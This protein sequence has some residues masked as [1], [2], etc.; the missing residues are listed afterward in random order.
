MSR[1]AEIYKSEK[2]KGGGL[3]SAVGKRF[4]EKVDPRK[5]FDQKGLMAAMLPSLF[6]SYSAT[7]KGRPR[8]TSISMPSISMPSFSSAAVEASLDDIYTSNKMIAKNSMVLPNIH[9][10]VNVMRQ[11]VVKLVKL[12]GGTAAT[13]ADMFFSKAKDREAMYES[14]FQKERSARTAEASK[15]TEGTSQG[16]F[17][18]ALLGGIGKAASGIGSGVAIASLGAGIGGFFTGLAAGGSAVNKLGGASGVKDMLIS[19]AQGLNAFNTQSLV[20]LGGMLGTGM[21]F[22]AVTGPAGAL[23]LGGGAA[24]G[25]TMIGAG[26]GGFMLALSAGAKVAQELGGPKA[27]KELLTSLGEGLD[28][29]TRMDGSNMLNVGKGIAALSAGLIGLFAAEGIKEIQNGYKWLKGLIF[30]EDTN[31]KSFFEELADQLRKLEVVDS[32][33]IKD[34]GE[35]FKDLVDSVDKLRSISDE[36][37]ALVGKKI[38]TISEQAKA[39][40]VISSQIKSPQFGQGNFVKAAQNNL[41]NDGGFIKASYTAAESTSPTSYEP[42]SAS[43]K[44]EM[45]NLIRQKFKAAGFTDIQ[46]EA[47]VANAIRESGLNPNAHNRVG[48]DSVGLFQMNRDRGLG[49]GYTV[50]QLKDPNFNIDLAIEAAKKSKSF[51]DA[52]TINGA[53]TAFVQDVERP[54]NQ[55]DEID[56]RIAIANAG[57]EVGKQ[58]SSSSSEVE[59]GKRQV[60]APVIIAPQTQTAQNAQQPAVSGQLAPADVQD[61]S[62]MKELF[63]KRAI[64]Y[65]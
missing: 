54:A 40:S 11:N 58:I 48:E 64:Q 53:I 50:E 47:A 1:I 23:A 16:G 29:F 5:I 3:A 19:L 65:I 18:G 20:A 39:A 44:N 24:V 56:K 33:K 59:D 25:M 12:Q 62:L 34:V 10:D 63:R 7:P 60:A 17:L 6:K 38:T 52:K 51:K 35:G 42:S 14:E 55:M 22:G 49:K 28:P 32:K 21:L 61:N 57:N 9:R 8:G 45:A 13:K 26:I 36:D 15:K 43:R 30:S 46:A 4:L 27:I 41:E 2:Q 37:I 31:K